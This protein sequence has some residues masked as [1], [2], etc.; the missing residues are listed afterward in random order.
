MMISCP[1]G[2]YGCSCRSNEAPRRF[3]DALTR[4]ARVDLTTWQH[5]KH[6]KNTFTKEVQNISSLQTKPLR[7]LLSL[8]LFWQ[9][10]CPADKHLGALEPM[11]SAAQSSYFPTVTSR[12]CSIG[13]REPRRQHNTVAITLQLRNTLR[14]RTS[15]FVIHSSRGTVPSWDSDAVARHPVWC[16]L[17]AFKTTWLLA[18]PGLLMVSLSTS[19]CR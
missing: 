5:V 12:L 11:V 14:V 2:T 19:V 4:P 7:F 9:C 16:I 17:R 8:D 3:E 6:V 10:S 15:G 18:L 1:F 13:S